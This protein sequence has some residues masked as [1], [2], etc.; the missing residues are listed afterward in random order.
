MVVW[1][2]HVWRRRRPVS[3][4]DD[5]RQ[6]GKFLSGNRHDFCGVDFGRG[7]VTFPKGQ[8]KTACCELNLILVNREL[9]PAEPG[10]IIS[11]TAGSR[12][13]HAFYPVHQGAVPVTRGNVKLPDRRG[14][15]RPLLVARVSAT[16]KATPSPPTFQ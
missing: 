2:W 8:P 3:G 16:P 12:Q 7:F 11:H 14:A 1:V 13:V 15:E 6:V 9:P 5:D 10:G 4:R